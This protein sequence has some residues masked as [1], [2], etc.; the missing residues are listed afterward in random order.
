MERTFP[1]KDWKLLRHLA[2]IALDR[3]CAR[4]LEDVARITAAPGKTSHE[5]YIKIYK[6]M[7]DR[8]RD[9]AFAFDDHRR[10][11]AMTKLARIQVLGLLTEDEL[12]GFSEETREIVSLLISR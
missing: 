2:P 4:V 9:L 1:E 8:D 12:R 3:Y 10:S 6:L 7:R 5:R 11:T